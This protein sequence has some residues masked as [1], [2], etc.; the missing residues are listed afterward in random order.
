M[1]LVLIMGVSFI[2]NLIILIILT[3]DF[4]RGTDKSAKKYSTVLTVF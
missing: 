2:Y 3:H 4:N 1:R